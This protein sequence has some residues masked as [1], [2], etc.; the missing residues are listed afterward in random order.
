[1][2]LDLQF[3]LHPIYERVAVQLVVHRMML[4]RQMKNRKI[5]QIKYL[6][7]FLIQGKA[8]VYGLSIIGMVRLASA[9]VHTDLGKAQ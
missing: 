2:L 8:A 3:A 4:V 1:M 7:T 9:H 5:K 6:I